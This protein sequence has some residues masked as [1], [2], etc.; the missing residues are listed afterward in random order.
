IAWR[1]FG[2]KSAG[3]AQELEACISRLLK[4]C[5]AASYF[6][7]KNQQLGAT[8]CINALLAVSSLLDFFNSLSS[9]IKLDGMT[10]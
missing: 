9:N 1:V 3:K 10:R 4:G 7:Q 8:L 6:N 5:T 2:S